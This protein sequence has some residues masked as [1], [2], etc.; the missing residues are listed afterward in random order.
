MELLHK[1]FAILDIEGVSLSKNR[2][3]GRKGRDSKIH[4]CLR[5]MAV[6]L[7]DGRT[8]VQEGWPCIERYALTDKEEKCFQWCSQNIHQ[9]SY[10][11]TSAP[12]CWLIPQM[13]TDFLRK[14][15]VEIVYYKGGLIEKDLCYE[16]NIPAYDLENIGVRKSPCHDPLKEVIFYG[17]ELYRIAHNF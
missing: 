6:L 13:L 10:T 17:A 14:N 1:Q 12:K 4:N 3:R 5:K 7:Y 11:P 16:I 9:L 8:A 15:H 2:L